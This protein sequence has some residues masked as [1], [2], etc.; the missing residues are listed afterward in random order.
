MQVC[1]RTTWNK[2]LATVVVIDAV[3]EPNSLE[4]DCE[5]SEVGA[6]PIT[7]VVQEQTFK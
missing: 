7:F 5:S 2:F 6:I 1:S 4:I 3:G